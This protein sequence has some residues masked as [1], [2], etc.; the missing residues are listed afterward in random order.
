LGQGPEGSINMKAFCQSSYALFA[1][2]WVPLY[3]KQN[4]QT[5][6]Q[7]NKGNAFLGWERER[8]GVI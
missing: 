3:N 6:K 1:A 5:N 7:T 4:K 2:P 8:N